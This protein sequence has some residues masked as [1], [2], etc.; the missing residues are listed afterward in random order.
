MIN[1]RQ[2]KSYNKNNFIADLSDIFHINFD[3]ESDDVNE[4]YMDWKNRFLFVADM[5]APP[6]TRRVRSEYTPWLTK[7]IMKEIKTRDYLKKKSS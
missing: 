3:Q 1:T 4:I 7:D 2:Y 5:H 6:I